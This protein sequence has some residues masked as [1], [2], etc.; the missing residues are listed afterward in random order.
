MRRPTCYKA[1]LFAVVLGACTRDGDGGIRGEWAAARE[2]RG[3][4]LV[5]RTVRGSVWRDTMVLVPELAIG[6]LE[7]EAPF[8]F[9]RIGWIDVDADGRLAVLDAQAREV[10]VFSPEGDHVRT[11]GRTGDGP[12]EFRSPMQVR[13]ASDGRIIVREAARFS[14][15]SPEGEYVAG[16][17]LRSGFSTN[18]PFFLDAND[19]VLS[20]TFRDSLVWYQLDGTAG[21]TVPVPTSGFD[22][23]RLEVTAGGGRAWY[24]IRF[25]PSEQWSLTQDGRVLFAVS[26][27]YALERWEPDGRVFRIER[28]VEPVP[29]APGEADQAREGTTRLIRRVNDPAWRWQGADIPSTKPAFGMLIAGADGTVWVIRSTVATEEQNPD[30]DPDRPEAGFPTRWVAPQVADVFDAEGQYLGPVNL[31]R[32]LGLY[33]TPLVTAERV[34]AVV[35][36]ELGHA[37]VV[38]FRLVP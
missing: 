34:W 19:R 7:G 32:E 5:V 1:V 2:E 8:V 29:V 6:E 33:P 16:W 3:D 35:L 27:R 37:Q 10:R 18:A 36:H 21:D 4:T 13:F 23:P 38:R 20:P 12:G 14:V 25:M 31:P 15:F 30:W 17:P 24:S 22:A 26:D 9:G 11:I 28:Q